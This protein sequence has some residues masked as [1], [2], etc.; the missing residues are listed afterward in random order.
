MNESWKQIWQDIRTALR[1]P[2]S[3]EQAHGATETVNVPADESP[4]GE[5]E[6]VAEAVQTQLQAMDNAALPTQVNEDVAT[7]EMPI[8]AESTEPIAERKPWGSRFDRLLGVGVVLVLGFLLWRNGWLARA[9]PPPAPNVVATFNGGQITVE[10]VQQ[11]LALLVPDI[12]MQAQFRDVESYRMIVQE[13]LSDELVRQW[14]TE[15]KADRDENLQHV[16]KHITEE[17]NLDELHAQMHKDQMG[18][19]EGDIQAYYEANR[20][21]FGDQ[22][23]TQVRDQIRGTLEAQQEDQFVANYIKGLMENA[24]ITRDFALLDVPEPEERELQAYYTANLAQYRLPAQAIV[25]EVRIV[26]GEDEVIARQQADKALVRLRAGEEFAAVAREVGGVPV[27]TGGVAI[28]AGVREATYDTMVFTLDENQISDV[29]QSGDTFYIVRLRSRQPERQHSLDEVRSQVRKAVLQEKERDWF[30]EKADLTLFTVHGKRYTVGEYWQEYQEL[31]IAF[32]TEYQ[33]N[34]GR[35]QLAE[36][37][38]ERMLLVE[39]S[40]DRLLTA[41]NESEL[42]EVRLDVLAQMMEQEEVDDQIEVTD[43]ELQTY[44]DQNQSMFVAPPQSRIRQILIRLGQTEDERKRAW[45]K[46]NEAYKQVAPGLFQQGEDFADVARQYSED[47]AT[48]GNGGEVAG[49]ISEGVDLLSELT[50][51]PLHQQVLSLSVGDISAPFEWDGAIYIIQVIERKEPEPLV[52]DGIK[53]LLREEL[54][55]RKHDELL[56]QLQ[57]KLFTTADIQIY[58]SVIATS[59]VES[60][61]SV[62]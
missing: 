15:R 44:Y 1:E 37:I 14:A 62:P 28:S 52:F 54:R 19:A 56:G 57:Q 17:I 51:H 42:E 3:R 21:Q 59:L 34:E 7:A 41:G 53:E 48:A 49:W 47:E 23:L 20:T 58:D 22:T 10:D 6:Q 36:Q 4:I 32:V 35:K 29:F 43:E 25:D 60:A 9:L 30:M 55:A 27:P 61:T 5:S 13:M 16:M 18:V 11:H 39:D 2:E 46:A 45:D 40:Y 8:V 50:E 33:G 24:T 38:I 12:T 26:V 31:P